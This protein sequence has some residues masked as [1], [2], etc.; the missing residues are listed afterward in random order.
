MTGA[1]RP[2]DI[3][4]LLALSIVLVATLLPFSSYVA[5]MPFIKEEWGLNNTQAG[6]IFSAYLAG[7]AVA[8]LLVVPLTD[9]LPVSRVFLASASTTVLSN[10]LFPL[11]AQDIVS[12]S[13][14]RAAA[15]V[16]LVGIYMPGLRL[17]SERFADSGKGAAMG[18]Y[19]TAF[20]SASAISLAA[21][22]GLMSRLEWR[23]AFLVLAVISAVNIPLAYLVTAGRQISR[24][25]RS[26][27][28][29]NLRVIRNRRAG[30]FILGYSLHA[31]ELYAVRVWLP[32]LL[33][34][35]LVASG[36]DPV[37]AAVK[38]ATIGGVALAAG[39]VGPLMG[40]AMSDRWGRT[41]TAAGIF[42]LSGACSWTIGWIG[43][44]PWPVVVGVAVVYGWAISADS[45]IYSTAV[46]ESAAA[47]DLGSTMAVQAFSGFMAGVLGPILIGAVLDVFPDSIDWGMGFSAIGIL[48]LIA[49]PVLLRIGDIAGGPAHSSDSRREQGQSA[50]R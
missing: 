47:G 46:T 24:G 1:V 25:P 14:L 39:S 23:D 45:S 49:V 29:L 8:A 43:D 36:V 16:G 27:G 9:R 11:V 37:D 50:D 34:A 19:V 42:A 18:L 5:A 10:I 32:G 7:Y 38:S 13:V 3:A 17:I 28:R 12:A 22:G 30:A 40:G 21:T 44:F 15:G 20:Y 26:T 2:R 4:W 35:V 41:R 33:M 48:A 6:A 31:M